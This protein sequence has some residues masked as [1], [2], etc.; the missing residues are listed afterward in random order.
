MKILKRHPY[1]STKYIFL[2]SEK[3][4]KKNILKNENKVEA[5]FDYAEKDFLLL[6]LHK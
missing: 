6:N 5:Q 2:I 4:V 1:N 3:I